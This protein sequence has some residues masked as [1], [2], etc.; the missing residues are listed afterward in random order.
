[1]KIPSY[2]AKVL[3]SKIATDPD[4][5]HQGLWYFNHYRCFCCA[6]ESQGASGDWETDSQADSDD[7]GE[8]EDVE[9]AS[10]SD[11]DEVRPRAS[12]EG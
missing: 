10:S 6:G 8:F 12:S 11:R 9:E 2:H 3:A 4:L 1:M 5:W 7:L